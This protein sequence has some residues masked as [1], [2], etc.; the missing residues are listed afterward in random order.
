MALL[1][2]AVAAGCSRGEAA[3]QGTVINVRQRDF[4]LTASVERVHAGLVTFRIHNSSP[5]THEF[6]VVRTDIA[7]DALPLRANGMTIN[8][9]SK[10]LHPVGELGEIRLD[11]KHDLTLRL[12]AGHYVLFCNLDGHYRGGMHATLEVTA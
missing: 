1:G 8:E 12:K 5:S 4:T 3:P 6:V 11:A 7:A 9:D 2:A 10:E